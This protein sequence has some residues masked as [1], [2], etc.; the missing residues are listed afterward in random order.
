MAVQP[1]CVHNRRTLHSRVRYVDVT[2][3]RFPGTTGQNNKDSA[4]PGM[5]RTCGRN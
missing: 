5:G 4:A 3:A 1:Q 2:T